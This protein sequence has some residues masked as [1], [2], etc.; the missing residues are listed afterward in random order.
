M[1]PRPLTH[2]FTVELSLGTAFYSR[3]VG[4]PI[5]RHIIKV[6]SFFLSFTSQYIQSIKMLVQRKSDL[7]NSE[8]MKPVHEAPPVEH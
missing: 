1:P 5:V 2:S 3:V 4:I 7:P 8:S 6:Y